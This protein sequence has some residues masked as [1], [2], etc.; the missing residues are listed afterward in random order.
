MNQNATRR[1]FLATVGTTG[2]TA[3]PTSTPAANPRG[4]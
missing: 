4:E 2:L 1:D 3:T